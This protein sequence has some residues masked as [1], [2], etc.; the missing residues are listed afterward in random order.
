MSHSYLLMGGGIAVL[1]F[2]MFANLQ[3]HQFTADASLGFAL[4][5]CCLIAI[6]IVVLIGE[7]K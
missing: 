2:D 6:G 7:E 3:P 4:I 5:G 1:I